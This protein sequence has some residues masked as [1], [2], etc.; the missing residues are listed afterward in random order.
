[1]VSRRTR[2]A[3]VESDRSNREGSRR[4]SPTPRPG[5]GFG[6]VAGGRGVRRRRRWG[7]RERPDE[8]AEV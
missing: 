7:S 4:A 5:P 3:P 1:M 6:L 8:Q 2:G